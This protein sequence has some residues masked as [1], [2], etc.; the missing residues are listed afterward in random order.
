M[1]KCVFS[2]GSVTQA[3]KAQRLLSEKAV[4]S[5]V[6]K[7]KSEQKGRGCRYGVDFDCMYSKAV[8]GIFLSY[9]I[10]YELPSD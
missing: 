10:N 2:V 5:K 1:T 6:V 8:K 9:G 7:T 4:P 3:M